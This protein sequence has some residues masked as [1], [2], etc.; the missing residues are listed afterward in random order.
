MKKT[1]IKRTTRIRRS[2]LESELYAS[3][4]ELARTATEY[5]GQ[6]IACEAMK[7]CGR[8]NAKVPATQQYCDRCQRARD[9]ENRVQT[10]ILP[11]VRTIG[12][13]AFSNPRP[14]AE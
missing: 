5:F 3:L 11:S 14:A 4:I 1:V 2:P 8:C 13:M 12:G 6:K 10:R 9:I 7:F